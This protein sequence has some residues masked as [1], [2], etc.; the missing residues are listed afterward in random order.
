LL[1]KRKKAARKR[2]QRQEEKERQ[3]AEEKAN[4]EKRKRLEELKR[5]FEEVKAEKVTLMKSREQ[6][7]K[8]VRHLTAEVDQKE[9]Q[10]ANSWR[11][12]CMTEKKRTDTLEEATA[13]QKK[14]IEL[15]HQKLSNTEEDMLS[16][17]L[18]SKQPVG[19]GNPS[20]RNNHL[21]SIRQL[22]IDCEN[23]KTNIENMN[24][25]LAEEVKK[26]N[27]SQQELKEARESKKYTSVGN[28]FRNTKPLPG[29]S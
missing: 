22:N 17:A 25:N 8:E 3:E 18:T 9:T 16:L 2:K 11:K 15:L 28:K 12:K 29:I 26:R 27:M 1:L 20:Q 24:R 5:K 13:K 7:V 19:K 23:L 21:N 6:V 14:E 4:E 10:A